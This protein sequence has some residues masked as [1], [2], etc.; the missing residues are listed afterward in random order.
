MFHINL[1]K[2]L[3]LESCNRYGWWV[4][5]RKGWDA[6]VYGRREGKW[7][8]GGS[9]KTLRKLVC[10]LADDEL[11]VGQGEKEDAFS[12]KKVIY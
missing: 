3:S 11:L 2:F 8:W 4:V 12:R 1:N 10:I 5:E 9:R 6:F 7:P